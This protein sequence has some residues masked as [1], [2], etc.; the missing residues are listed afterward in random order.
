MRVL[1]EEY[2]VLE[3]EFNDYADTYGCACHINPPCSYC[4]H[5]GNP[6]NLENTP[7]AW[8]EVPDDA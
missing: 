3:E 6:I 4:E 8:E 7:E 5:E 2:R 1:K